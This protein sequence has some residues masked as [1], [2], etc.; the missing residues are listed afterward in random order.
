MPTRH[1]PRIL[2]LVAATA[3]VATAL[4]ACSDDADDAPDA[5]SITALLERV[6]DT[7]ANGRFVLV[8]LYAEAERDAGLEPQGKA[9]KAREL[10]RLTRL[11]N[12]VDVGTGLPGGTLAASPYV[13]QQY[14]KLGYVPSDVEAEVTFGEPPSQGSVGVG[15]FDEDEVL[16]RAADVDGAERREVEGTR[17]VSWLDDQKI[18]LDLET[19]IGNLPG[20][21]GRVAAPGGD[22][23]AYTND[24]AGMG[25]ILATADGERKSLA[26]DD[27]LRA[28][29]EGLDDADVTGAY[30][31]TEPL[32]P[33]GGFR[34][35]P[36]GSDGAA[37]KD[38]ALQPYV[39]FGV[40]AALDDGTK[41]LV[42][43]LVHEDDESARENAGRLRR[44]VADG[45]SATT[46]RPW[47]SLLRAADVEQ[48][49]RLVEATFEVDDP[50]L[51][52]KIVQ[53]RDHLLATS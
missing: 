38:Q 27:D 50:T 7:E 36:G 26:D 12:D 13:A 31:S 39:A 51:W 32:G 46:R 2:A 16:D 9:G 44:I 17:V 28:V 33:A 52:L 45:S 1:A 23:L 8:S 15:T 11:T 19:P 10:R 6:P 40:G 24:D 43:V 53:Q 34:R 30:L 42:V 49:G 47:K 35:R 3:L 21:A 22:L 29:A 48:D 25:R 20:R 4:G 37:A 14:G 5:G 18:D 41:E